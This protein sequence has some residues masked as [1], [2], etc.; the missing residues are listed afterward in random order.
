MDIIEPSGA[1]T[2]QRISRGP[3][4][5]EESRN[6]TCSPLEE[7]AGPLKISLFSV[8][9]KLS[10]AASPTTTEERTMS[11]YPSCLHERTSVTKSLLGS[12]K[13][14]SGRAICPS[15]ASL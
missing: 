12:L 13:V 9:L 2:W 4:I 7:D 15:A 11:V 6:E 14:I 3:V 10:T 1:N 5:E 8:G